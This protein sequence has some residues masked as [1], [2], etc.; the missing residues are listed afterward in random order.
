MPMLQCGL[1]RG[2]EYLYGDLPN[3]GQQDATTKHLCTTKF[4]D[5]KVG[6]SD[7]GKICVLLVQNSWH[8]A[9]LFHSGNLFFK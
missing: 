6:K 3:P 8:F 4:P 5:Q 9:F 1:Q 2:P 7:E